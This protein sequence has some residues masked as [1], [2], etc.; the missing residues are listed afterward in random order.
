MKVEH[1]AIALFIAS[2]RSDQGNDGFNVGEEE[3]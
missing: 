1:S 2:Y 3:Y